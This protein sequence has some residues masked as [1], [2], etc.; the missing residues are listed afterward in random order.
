MKVGIPREV[1]NHE[2]R[3]AI[4]PAG[5]NEFTRHGHEVFVEAGAGVGSSI[6][7]DEF[8][9]AGA[10]ILATAD[11]VWDTADLVLKVKEPIA[12]EY[13]RMREGQ[14]LFTYLHLA[15]SRECT[16]ALVDRKV[17]GIAYETVELPDRSLPLLAP[18]SEVAGRLA[19][20][21]GA[22]YMMRT[23]G[24]RG[25]LPG[26]VSGVYAAKTVVIGAGVSGLNAAAIALGLQ[27]EVLLLDKNVA[28]LRQADAIYRGHLQTVASNA[29]E[30][31][32]AVLDADLVIGAVL[33]PGA[34]APKLISNEL[35]SRM[36]PGSVLVDIAIDQGGCFEDSR[37][38]THAD[39]VY[40][41]HDSI[42]YCVANMPG[43]V[44]NT[45]TYALT[46][47][48]LPYALELANQGWQQALRNDPALALGLNTHAGK[49]VYGPVAE[50]HGMDVLPLDEVLS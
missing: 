12:E 7:D 6:T 18:M 3:V 27:S 40:K 26:G 46:N 43:A 38:T 2:Y 21:V 9:A 19:P 15:A 16:D 22:F 31:E 13:H 39:P 33:V 17:T 44:P 11:E 5:V 36:K 10:K 28:R 42:F 29:Y 50:A 20:Q 35:V 4:T 32:R 45:S 48:T 47:V 37:P 8:A 41:V 25:V 14:V 49:V 23:G 1:K 34:K 24:G 30:I